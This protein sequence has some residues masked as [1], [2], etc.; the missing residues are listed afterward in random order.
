MRL[1]N[2]A[3]DKLMGFV[4]RLLLT[5]HVAIPREDQPDWLTK[6]ESIFV[7]AKPK[8]G[9]SGSKKKSA[10]AQPPEKK[11]ADKKKAAA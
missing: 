11:N 9:K 7:P 1:A 6:A 10:L 5:E 4:L 8:T 3:D 2:C